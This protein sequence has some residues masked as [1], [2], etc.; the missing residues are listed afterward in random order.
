MSSGRG[1][2]PRAWPLPGR[3]VRP[4][5]VLRE[6]VRA[7]L[8]SPVVTGCVALVVAA[9]CLVVLATTG[10]AAAAEDRVLD[11]L[12]AVGTRTVVVSD[13]QGAAG[14][15]S[16]SIPT[17]ATLSGV[18]A[19]IGLGPASDVY[20]TALPVSGSGVAARALVGDVG[21]LGPL[22]AGRP[23][24]VGES[25][26]AG[27]AAQRLGLV[28]GVG[29]V[30]TD[31]LWAPTRDL[32][33]VGDVALVPDLSRVGG[34]VY[35][36][37]EPCLD[38]TLRHVYV[39]VEDVGAVDQVV[40]DLPSV[41]TARDARSLSVDSSPELRELRAVVAGDLAQSSRQ[42]M[43][44]VLAVGASLVT[45]TMSGFVSVRRRDFGRR[46][47]LGASR[48]TV[49]VIVAVQ[50]LV[51]SVAGAAVGTLGGLVLT[52]HLAGALPG[53]RFV[54]GVA[55][56]AV[57]TTVLAAGPAALSAAL[58]DPVRILRVP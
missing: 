9:S 56:L 52:H 22:R 11:R 34:A 44:L 21:A 29:A 7:A 53:P 16:L 20:A 32:D 2:E 50:A 5:R 1:P 40:E 46:R 12:D 47:A 54:V 51:A 14:L 24:V 8:T 19:V 18:E 58:R 37:A 43:V 33:V 45:I 41:V 25:V 38:L 10:R 57:L 28:E 49:L 36:L 3:P 26:A 6:G 30:R 31:G 55:V 23:P 39:V 13:A 48:S 15:S 4:G 27:D 17:L 35:E 42:L